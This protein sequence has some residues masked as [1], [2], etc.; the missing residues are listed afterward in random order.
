MTRRSLGLIVV[1]VVLTTLSF[2]QNFGRT[3]GSRGSRPPGQS[4]PEDR[5]SIPAETREGAEL[6]SPGATLAN[7]DNVIVNL[8]K[9]VDITLIVMFISDQAKKPVIKDLTVQ[10]KVTV[11]SAEKVPKNQAL[12]VIYDALELMG[13]AVVETPREI[14]LIPAEL[15]KTMRITILKPNES[16]TSITNKA[17]MVQ[18]TFNLLVASPKTVQANIQPLISKQGTI[19]TDDRTKTVVVTDTALNVERF[20]A[21]VATFDRLGTERFITKTMKLQYATADEIADLIVTMI[22][23]GE[24]SAGGMISRPSYGGEDHGGGYRRYGGGGGGVRTAGEVMMIPDPRTNWLVLAGLPDR[25]ARI[26]KLVTDFDVPG[27]ADVRRVLG[28]EESVSSATI[29]RTEMVQKIFKLKITSPRSVQMALQ[30]L[31]SRQGSI[32]TDERTKSVIITDTAANIQRFEQLIA[33]L[34]RVEAGQVNIKIFKLQYANADELADL[35]AMM[36]VAGEAGGTLPVSQRSGY[37][38][39]YGEDS[40]SRRRFGGMGSAGGRMAGDLVVI[41]DTRTNWLIVAGP[42]DKIDRIDKLITEIDAPG[43]TDVKIQA[44]DVKHADAFDLAQDIGQMLQQKIRREKQEVFDIRSNQRGNQLL[45]LASPTMFKMVQ[46]VV[47]QLDTTQSVTRETRTYELKYMD[48]NDMADQLNQLYQEELGRVLFGYGYGGGRGGG[49]RQEARFVPS[50]RSNSLMVIAQPQEYEFIEK[51]IKELDVEVP[52][53]NLAPRVYHIVHTDAAQMVTVLSQLFEGT[54][55]RQGVSPELFL[56]RPRT[57][58]SRQ[59][60][61]GALYGKVRF[62]VYSNTNSIVAITNNVQ[63]FAVIEGLIKELDVLDPE[64]TDMLVLQIQFADVAE[65]ANNLNNVMSEGAVTRPPT[66]PRPSGGQQQQGGQ[67]GAQQQPPVGLTEEAPQEVIFPWQSAARRPTRPGEE[68]RPISAL[69]NHVRIVPDLRS[70]KLII[71]APSIYF[72]SIKKLVEDLDKPEPQVQL[73]TYIVRVDTE[74]AMRLGWRWTPDASSVSQDELDNA[75]LGLIDMGFIDTFARGNPFVQGTGANATAPPVAVQNRAVRDAYR[76][77]TLFSYG[78]SL[79]PG[80]GVL[81]ADINLALLV[82]LLIKN[83]NASVVAHPQITVNNNEMGE[84]FV[85]ES[86]PFQ[87]SAQASAEGTSVR[88][89]FVYKDVGTRLQI[90]PQ[91]NKQGRVVLAIYMENSRR[92]PELVSGQIVTEQQTYNTK[93]TV[94]NGQ[95]VWLGGLSETRDENIIRKFPLLGDIPWIGYLFRKTDKTTLESKLYAFITPQVLETPEQAD[96]QFQSAKREVD[97]YWMRY[98]KMA[99]RLPGE[100]DEASSFTAAPRPLPPATPP[101]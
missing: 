50:V 89:N 60:Q 16:A 28:A 37:G 64:A 24:G 46:E 35:V 97:K 44:V 70:Q 30:P 79:P 69:I 40:S 47:E 72:D 19:I 18:K 13:I 100:E 82:Q 29:S 86:L 39:G 84:I 9:G 20:E 25:V 76:G 87:E 23:A 15:A 85:G 55:S 66:S 49:Q 1:F 32:G 94:E 7:R 91:I 83:R 57:T 31:L 56:F 22:Q 65:L 71:A 68:E 2:G 74:G 90:K 3:R 36:A 38:G 8:S 96:A 67:G 14:Q 26:E 78:Q 52:E 61:V 27:R 88:S 43:R 6:T 11:Y 58:T 63:N 53:E 10:G 92:K 41:P 33:A 62:V 51:M 99:L 21:L 42:Q 95:K 17:Q 54:T 34:D 12:Q 5:M 98:Q 4:S 45:V 59:G 101:K 93:L 81:S 48:A 80:K 77:S 75:F 73:E